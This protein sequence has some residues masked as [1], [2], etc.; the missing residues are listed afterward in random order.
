MITNTATG[1]WVAYVGIVVSALAH[2]GWIVD[3]NTV[4]TIIAGLVALGGVIYQHYK[5]SQVVTAARVS[6]VS[7]K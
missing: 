3:Q 1:S 2:F 6:G 5:T 7:I 4:I